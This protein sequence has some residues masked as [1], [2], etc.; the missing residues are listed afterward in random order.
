MRLPHL[1]LR[2]VIAAALPVM[3]PGP[4][5]AQ[6]TE[7]LLS[8]LSTVAGRVVDHESSSPLAGASISITPVEPGAPGAATRFSD[9]DGAF[10]FTNL[11]PGDY[12][13]SVSSPGYHSAEHGLPV[14]AGSDVRLLVRLSPSP[15]ELEPLVVVTE[16]RPWFMDGFEERRADARLH[17]GFFTQDEISALHARYISDVLFTVPGVAVRPRLFGSPVVQTP[18]AGRPGNCMNVFVNGSFVGGNG[19]FGGGAVPYD[20]MYPPDD[21]AALEVYALAHD[22]PQQFDRP[23]GCGA[24]AIWLRVRGPEEQ[25]A[26][27]WKRVLIGL[28]IVGAALLVTR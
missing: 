13:L 3:I 6:L 5:G 18:Y 16:R 17:T 20:D 1:P 24:I 7:Q 4:L 9:D 25:F 27:A 11:A 14:A 15:I 23:G 21:I 12:V 28:G 8:T 10:R 22:L 2:Y 26:P 19:S